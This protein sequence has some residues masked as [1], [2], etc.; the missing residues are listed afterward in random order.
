M[1]KG[2]RDDFR[3][4]G[5]VTHYELLKHLRSKRMIVFAAIGVLLIVLITVLRLY[6]DAMSSDSETFMSDYLGLMML[7]IIIGVSLFCAPAIA[8]EF[9]ERTALL[10]FPRPIKK[11]T[12]LAGKMLA[13]YIVVGVVII[14]YYAIC[15]ILS[16]IFAH[17]LNIKAFG[18]L[19]LA[20]LFMLGAGGFAFFLS[21][22]SKK[23]STAIVLAIVILLLVFW[24]IIDSITALYG[25]EPVFSLTY[26]GTDISNIIDGTVTYSTYVDQLGR[27]VWSFYPSH[28]LSVGIMTV[29]FAVTTVLSALIFRRREF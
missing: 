14:L 16:L 2:I 21:S 20:L 10:V 18:S 25:I 27:D 9:E 1:V 24:M 7:F 5:V 12:F 23:G 29:W 22:I 17:G 4:I 6:F 28:V 19:G 15:M 8:S 3:Q 13:C 11:S 26:A